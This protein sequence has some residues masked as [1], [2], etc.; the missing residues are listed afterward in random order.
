MKEKARLTKVKGTVL[1]TVVSVMMVLIVFLMGTLALAATANNRAN[2]NYQKEQTE[3]TARA[4]LDAVV[5]AINQ[6]D[7]KVGGLA[8]RIGSLATGSEINFDVTIDDGV[9]PKDYP[10][11]IT[12][13]EERPFYADE[14]WQKGS[15]YSVSTTVR[16]T[17]TDVETV[18][19]AYM[20]DADV[21]TGNGGGGGGGGGGA[22]VSMGSTGGHI[23]TSGFV[24]GG[25]QIGIN[26]DS[27]LDITMD[28]STQIMAPV[29]VNGNLT[30]RS[31]VQAYF[32]SFSEGQHFAV[33]GDLEVQAG[34][35]GVACADDMTLPAGDISYKAIPTI[36]VGGTLKHTDGDGMDFN[37][38]SDYP[39]NV[40]CGNIEVKSGSSKFYMKGD[41]HCFN[42]NATSRL[43]FASGGADSSLYE[44][45]KT[46]VINASGKTE[47]T[48]FGNLYSKGN[49][50]L[51]LHVNGNVYVEKN[52]TIKGT[53]SDSAVTVGKTQGGDVV[54]GNILT[55]DNNMTLKCKNVIANKLIVNGELECTNINANDICGSGTVKATNVQYASSTP[56]TQQLIWYET[57]PIESQLNDVEG[58]TVKEGYKKYTYTKHI[59]TIYEDGTYDEETET[60]VKEF[61]DTL[62]GEYQQGQYD[63]FT[64]D[65]DHITYN[66]EATAQSIPVAG[67]G[68]PNGIPDTPNKSPQDVKTM[69][70]GNAIYP[71]EYT[72]DRVY[73]DIIGGKPD[74]KKYEYPTTLDEMNKTTTILDADNKLSLPVQTYSHGDTIIDSSCIINTGKS[75]GDAGNILIQPKTSDAVVIVIQG[76][77]D[78]ASGVNIYIDD[79]KAPV[80]FYIDDNSSLKV[81]GRFMT[82]KY[83][84]H[85]FMT[86]PFTIKQ[87]CVVSDWYYPNVYIYS[88]KNAKMTLVDGFVLTA[89][90]RAPLLEY[91][92][93]GSNE[94]TRKA[95]LSYEVDGKVVK[96]HAAGE[97]IGLYGQ[98]IAGTINVENT[99]GMIYVTT[100][101][102]PCKCGHCSGDP[103]TCTCSGTG[104]SGGCPTTGCSSCICDNC[105]GKAGGMGGGSSSA[106]PDKLYTMYYNYY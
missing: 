70:G 64:Y 105:P 97:S 7:K 91:S 8:D 106:A 37:N 82:E 38:G 90:V 28:N 34:T 76:K 18:Y 54:V 68:K 89:N 93:T 73:N 98:L 80:Y 12:K 62:W 95:E 44:W 49:V 42:E 71:D 59:K 17:S 22:F 104:A 55:I 48:M 60:G 77:V 41:L 2:R 39:I 32:S 66:S 78:M 1:F 57:T 33:T 86:N 61:K 16:M 74:A 45:T 29:Y 88:G 6:D 51:G 52:L 35:L 24:A 10:V 23:G 75:N 46:N 20:S 31:Q 99:W 5:E 26:S 102:E 96:K 79:K 25:T 100:E 27:P 4:V 87:K 94:V 21:N 47:S 14:K 67:S 103:A 85:L 53:N 43:Y 83:R 50:D 65:N 63:N 81:Q 9:S 13:T 56:V 3:A 84:D 15:V 11:T 69:N 72:Q 101:T 58:Q 19:T 36:Y 40:Y 92:H 30:T